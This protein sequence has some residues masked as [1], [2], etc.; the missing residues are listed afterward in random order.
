MLKRVSFAFATLSLCAPCTAQTSYDRA[1]SNY[2]AIASGQKSWH[3][4]TPIEA[5]EVR[6]LDAA[7]RAVPRLERDTRARCRMRNKTSDVPSTLEEAVLDLK[8]S[9]QPE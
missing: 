6:Q 7:L 5:D 4:L 8:C 2:R 9:Q 1:Y 3:D